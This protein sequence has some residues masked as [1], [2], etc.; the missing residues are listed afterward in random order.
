MFG[1]KLK[2]FG[3]IKEVWLCSPFSI[4]VHRGNLFIDISH[5]VVIVVLIVKMVKNE[6]QR[7]SNK[8]SIIRMAKTVDGH[9]EQTP[10]AELE[11]NLELLEDY[12]TQFQA[13]QISIEAACGPQNIEFQIIEMVD[14][15]RSYQSTKSKIKAFIKRY[16]QTI[17]RN[18]QNWNCHSLTELTLRG[19][20]SRTCSIRW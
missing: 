18:Y 19:H 4:D 9:T 15:E 7:D 12:W 5:C 1:K 20:R 13:V 16:E 11:T 6:A 17:L 10:L 2:H 3:C 14:T 8:R